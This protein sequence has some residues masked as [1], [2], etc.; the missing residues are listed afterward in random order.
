MYA[1][2]NHH[3]HRATTTEEH[4]M[5]SSSFDDLTR[6]FATAGTRNRRR[7]LAALVPGAVR[8]AVRP[9]NPGEVCGPI[10]DDY[11]ECTGNSSCNFQRNP[12]V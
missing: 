2:G 6:A 5:D 7:F 8:A 9:A 10:G 1:A 3:R 4:P 12:P 11:Y